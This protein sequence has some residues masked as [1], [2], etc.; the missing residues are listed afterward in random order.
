MHSI[1]P[2]A[3]FGTRMRPH[4][5]TQP[6][7]LLPVAG[8]PILG[9]IL[10]RLIAAGVTSTTIV[11]GY[12]G[13]KVEEYVRTAYP[14]IESSFVEQTELLGLGHSIWTA[15][16]YIPTNGDPL[17]I[18]LG[19]TIFDVD[20]KNVFALPTSALCVRPVEDPRR[21]G[22]A[23]LEGG[24]ISKLVEKPEHPTTNLAIVGLY[25]FRN[26]KLLAECLDHI[27]SN[28][29]RTRN[30]YQ[31]TD[32]LQLMIDRGEK[33][34]TFEI[35]AWYDCGKPETLLETN[36]HLLGLKQQGHAGVKGSLIIDPVEIAEGA[37]VRNSVIGPY[38]SIG[39]GSVVENTVVR[40]SI[41]G[42][43]CS[44]INLNLDLS[45]VGNSAQ[46]AGRPARLNLGDSTSIEL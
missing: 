40:D 12:L 16:E 46:A 43:N 4:T 17:F 14:N 38:V 39:A 36:R 18:I 11:V 20:L 41:V 26:P 35:E 34:S 8:K 27:V 32:A 21:F 31:L 42:E 15:R 22:V 44:L 7:V 45:I 33:F 9:H 23:E 30:E 1:I 24:Y 5:Y 6:K 2:V 13:D 28:D 25:F 3:G 19:D 29:I 37:E 10:D